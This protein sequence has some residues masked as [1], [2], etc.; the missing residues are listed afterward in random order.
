MTRQLVVWLEWL[1]MTIVVLWL[2]VGLAV[3]AGPFVAAVVIGPLLVVYGYGEQRA[4]SR[5]S[6]TW[7]RGWSAAAIFLAAFLLVGWLAILAALVVGAVV[8]IR[9]RRESV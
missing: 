1:V 5:G 9:S 3:T 4:R 6:R 7:R 8:L 2:I